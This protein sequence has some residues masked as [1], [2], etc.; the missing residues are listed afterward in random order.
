MVRSENNGAVIC[1]EHSLTIDYQYDGQ[2][3][4]REEW[5][6][7][8]KENDDDDDDDDDRLSVAHMPRISF[9]IDAQ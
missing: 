1:S 4:G 2:T 6:Q 8:N 7:R 9:H 5:R 3:N